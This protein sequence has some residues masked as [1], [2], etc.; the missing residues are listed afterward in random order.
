M[1]LRALIRR[2]ITHIREEWHAW[3]PRHPVVRSLCCGCHVLFGLLVLPPAYAY[4]RLS[5]RA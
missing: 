1:T 4:M 2:N 5:G 3:L